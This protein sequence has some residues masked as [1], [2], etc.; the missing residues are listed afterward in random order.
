[1]Q[2][3]TYFT[4]LII[5][6]RLS[7]LSRLFELLLQIVITPAMHPKKIIIARSPVLYSLS[8]FF[9]ILIVNMVII[10]TIKVKTTFP[11]ILIFF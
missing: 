7:Y 5:L 6:S 4:E 9:I 10:L 2:F 11:L 1:M 8:E 3:L